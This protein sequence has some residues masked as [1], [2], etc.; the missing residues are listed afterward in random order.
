MSRGRAD[1]ANTAMRIFLQEMGSAYDQERG[2]TPYRGGPDFDRVVEFFDRRCCY[3]GTNFT[4]DL[5]AV[6]DH[7]IPM[8]RTDLGLHAWGNIVAACPPCNAKKQGRDWKDFI[9]ERA[10]ADARE[11]HKR[12]SEFIKEYEYRPALD[13]A[14]VASELYEEIGS[15][16]MTLIQARVK[17]IR[18]KL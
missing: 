6:Q 4:S 17:R 7:L 14:D 5:R 16:S 2:L 3:C 12:V 13:L 1:I 11:R 15:I 18:E 8:N 9:I 10:G